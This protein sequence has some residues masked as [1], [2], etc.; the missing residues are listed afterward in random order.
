[1]LPPFATYWAF[2]IGFYIFKK[3][4]YNFF[5]ELDLHFLGNSGAMGNI[6]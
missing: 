2:Q 6:T 1:M 5:L 3:L 4:D